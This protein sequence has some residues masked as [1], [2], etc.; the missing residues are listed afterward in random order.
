VM[1]GMMGWRCRFRSEGKIYVKED[2]SVLVFEVL[3]ERRK[4]R[5]DWI[6]VFFA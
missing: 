1:I 5:I 2:L 6:W 4:R 3:N